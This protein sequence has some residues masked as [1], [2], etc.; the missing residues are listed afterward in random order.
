MYHALYFSIFGIVFS[1]ISKHIADSPRMKY[2]LEMGIV[3]GSINDGYNTD[4][5]KW[6]I[7]NHPKKQYDKRSNLVKVDNPIEWRGV[8]LYKSV[9]F[10]MF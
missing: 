3:R 10:V 8:I 5:P 7:D 6:S 2:K 9:I 1:R 4:P